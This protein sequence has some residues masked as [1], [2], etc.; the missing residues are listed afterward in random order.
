[1][2]D[3]NRLNKLFEETDELIKNKDTANTDYKSEAKDS[4]SN[5]TTLWLYINI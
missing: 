5:Y 1:L 2:E 3:N 4:N